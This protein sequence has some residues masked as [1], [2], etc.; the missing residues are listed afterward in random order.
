M[1]S[2]S[3][4]INVIPCEVSVGLD[5]RLLPGFTPEDMLKEL[6]EVIGD[7]VEIEVIAFEP[8]PTNLNMSFFPVLADV[9]C[10]MD[11]DGKPIPYLLSGVT[12]ARLFSKLGIQTYGFLPMKLSPEFSFAGTIHAANERIPVEALDFGAEAIYRAIQR[13]A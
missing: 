4:K 7:E 13:A 6:L 5:G 2:A 3:D 9:L 1:L 11:P 12:D 8:G 10:E